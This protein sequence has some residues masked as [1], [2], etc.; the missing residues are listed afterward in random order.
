M[1][2]WHVLCNSVCVAL[3]TRPGSLSRDIFLMIHV[4]AASTARSGRE[5]ASG[6]ENS[7]KE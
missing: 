3:M 2:K 6:A 1:R 4:S 7:C 5:K